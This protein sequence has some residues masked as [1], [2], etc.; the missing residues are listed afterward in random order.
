MKKMIILLAV[1]AIAVPAMA[2]VTISLVD[3]GDGTGNLNYADT[4]TGTDRVRAFAL[5][6]ESASADIIDVA[7][8]N[9]H[10]YDIYPGDINIDDNTITDYGSCVC[11][12]SEYGGTPDTAR[13][14]TIEM[15][16]LYE[17]AA[18]PASSGTLAIIT[19][20]PN[21]ASSDISVA[22]NTIRGGVVLE[23]PDTAPV[24][25]VT[26]QP[27]TLGTITNNTDCIPSDAAEYD[28]WVALGKPDCW[29]YMY[30]CRGD[31]DHATE[32][33][34]TNWRVSGNDLVIIANNWKKKIDDTSLNPCADI[35]HQ[36][37]GLLTAWR[38]SPNDLAILA[39]NWKAKD[40]DLTVCP[41][42]M[43]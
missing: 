10:G 9:S 15:G 4:G 40:T 22:L 16:S 26:S 28:D 17:G 19:I 25:N 21:V 8:P 38:V 43:E 20:D 33:L 32:G 41:Y 34:L 24:V 29:C 11:D 14:K 3:N 13:A 27:T 37:E 36:S 35:D 30:Q 5:E 39:S 12:G 1:L 2:D 7:C 31:A 6:I 18:Y 42:N 23:N